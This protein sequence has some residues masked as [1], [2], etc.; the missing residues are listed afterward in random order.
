MGGDDARGLETWRDDGNGRGWGV[1]TWRA[2]GNSLVGR[3]L[4]G[5]IG[6]QYRSWK[7]GGIYRS[8]QG[9]GGEG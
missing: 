4:G 3:R 6:I 2:D 8:G 5:G 9:S 1:E 7:A